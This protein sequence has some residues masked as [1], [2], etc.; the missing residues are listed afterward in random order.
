MNYVGNNLKSLRLSVESSLKRL[1]TDYIDVLYL[2]YWDL[3]TTVEEFMDGLHNLVTEG[4]VLYLVRPSPYLL[5]RSCVLRL[6]GRAGRIR[7]PGVARD[8]GE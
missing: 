6:G 8:K 3:H 5:S 4:K 1:R 7:H 2:H